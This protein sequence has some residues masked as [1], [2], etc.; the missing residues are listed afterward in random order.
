MKNILNLLNLY[1]GK[2]KLTVKKSSKSFLI[3]DFTP[4]KTHTIS[5]AWK[6]PSFIT[7]SEFTQADYILSH[8]FIFFFLFPD[9]ISLRNPHIKPHVKLYSRLIPKLDGHSNPRNRR[10][11]HQNKS[12][13][14][15]SHIPST[16]KLTTKAWRQ[17]YNELYKDYW[18]GFA[19]SAYC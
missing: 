8:I 3:T 7:F 12:T 2:P 15:F 19:K 10:I 18:F 5:S 6:W 9:L 11:E 13:I 4:S 14:R 16:S 17:Q 1:G